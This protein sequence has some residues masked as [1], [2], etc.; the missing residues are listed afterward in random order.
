MRDP[1]VISLSYVVEPCE[2]I[3]F[4]QPSAIRYEHPIGTFVLD[5]L[6]LTITLSQHFASVEEAKQSADRV[7]MA[8]EIQAA[9][10]RNLPV[11]RFRFKDGE[12]VDRDPVPTRGGNRIVELAAHSR[13]EITSTAFCDTICNA[14]PEPP[15]SFSVTP[16]VEI[17]YQ[18]W[19]RS[20]RGEEPLLAMAYFVLTLIESAAGG[21]QKA[22]SV[23]SVD[24]SILREL[25]R[26]T[27]TLGDTATARKADSTLAFL[28]LSDSERAWVE[29]AVKAIVKRM[30]EH[31]AGASVETIL[32][33][34]LPALPARP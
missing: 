25:G 1:H 9:L 34:D 26:I 23:F 32:M 10:A 2:T 29:S 17:A 15:T 14:Y 31:A 13:V 5:D 27:S 30:G 24:L 28:P 6:A 12:V 33:S 7:L 4:D 3:S 19:L 22:S 11:I 21:R 8:W 18:R 20:C 16:E